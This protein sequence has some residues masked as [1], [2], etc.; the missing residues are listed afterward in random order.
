MSE[1]EAAVAM[2]HAREPAES[3]LLMRRSERK[4]DSWSGHWSFPGGRRDVA[5]RD[6]LHTALRE[7][8]EECGV[9]LTRGDLK[10]EMP[11]RRARRRSGAA[12]RV[13]P[14]L[15]RVGAEPAAVPDGREAVEASWIPL[16]F[17]RDPG[18]HLLLPVPGHPPETLYP[19]VML[20]RAPLW[21]FTYRLICDWLALGPKPDA[22]EQAGLEA[23]VEVLDFLRSR[24]LELRRG[25]EGTRERAAEVAGA[26]P[27]A[28]VLERFSRPGAYA[29]SVSCL[30][31]RPEG[32]R[33]VGPA[34]E[35]YRIDASG[36]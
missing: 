6:L 13:T 28:E 16:S 23:A 33:I 34:F 18:R 1:A 21:G 7:L 30:E 4:E 19:G 32:I 24:G 3:V 35:E 10:E 25:W 22:A 9:R 11:L 36:T 29:L 2:V 31:V 27:V 14:F 5:D 17:L 15:F 8:E 20:G 26:I 12:I